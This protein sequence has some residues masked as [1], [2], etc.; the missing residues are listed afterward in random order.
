MSINRLVERIQAMK[1]TTPDDLC[2]GLHR[3]CLCPL[4]TSDKTPREPGMKPGKP[5]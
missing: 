5:A 1:P 3:S 2:N 4:C